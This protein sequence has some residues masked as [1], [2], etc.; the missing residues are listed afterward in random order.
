M[1]TYET[2]LFE[3]DDGI[4]WVT[5]NRPEVRNAINQQMQDE[6]RGLWR[7]LRHDDEVRCI[8]LGAEGQ[9]FCTGIDRGEAI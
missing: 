4:A 2:L 8:V 1:P 7:D 3:K 9:S 6:L 5:L